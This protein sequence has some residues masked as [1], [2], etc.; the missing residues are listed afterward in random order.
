MNTK[1]IVAQHIFIYDALY[2]RSVLLNQFKE[3]LMVVGLLQLIQ[4]FPIK[5]STLFTYTGD[6]STEEV[7]EAVYMEGENIIA[8]DEFV[9]SLFQEYLKTLKASGKLPVF[10]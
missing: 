4:A 5:L 9:F 1:D 7:L 3:G 8:G 10:I 6:V 2:R